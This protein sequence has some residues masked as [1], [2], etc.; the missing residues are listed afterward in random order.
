MTVVS[1]I[2]GKG[3]EYALYLYNIVIKMFSYQLK[4]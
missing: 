2:E 4:M 1:N 3:G